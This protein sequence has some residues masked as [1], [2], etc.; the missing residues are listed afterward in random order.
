MLHEIERNLHS[1]SLLSRNDFPS[2][3]ASGRTQTADI[4]CPEKTLLRKLP[5]DIL[6]CLVVKNTSF[7]NLEANLLLTIFNNLS[8]K[9]LSLSVCGVCRHWYRVARNP[10]LWKELELKGKNES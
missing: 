7:H 8:E 1:R 10:K 6:G 2:N 4:N 5:A 3:Y 9:E